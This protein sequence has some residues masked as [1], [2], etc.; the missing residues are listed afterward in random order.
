MGRF[1]VVGIGSSAAVLVVLSMASSGN[2]TGR[3]GVGLR[4]D[5]VV[6]GL[7]LGG[8]WVL[9]VSAIGTAAVLLV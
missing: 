5:F 9:V 6:A 3:L 1:E 8:L 7:A 4:V 2:G